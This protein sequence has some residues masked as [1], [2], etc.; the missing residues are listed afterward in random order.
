MYHPVFIFLVYFL[1]GYVYRPVADLIMGGQAPIWSVT[2]LNPG[3]SDIIYA[4]VVSIVALGSFVFLPLLIFPKAYDGLVIIRTSFKVDRP[5]LFYLTLGISAMLGIVGL[6]NAFWTADSESL[7]AFATRVQQSGGQEL[8]GISGYETISLHF[9]PAVIILLY[10]RLG[11]KAWLVAVTA[12]YL[13]FRAYFGV[14][15]SGFVALFL[16]LLIAHMIRSGIR[17]FNLKHLAAAVLVLF[18]FDVIGGNRYA[19]KNILSGAATVNEVASDYLS[20]RGAGM[21]L[22]DLEEFESTTMVTMIV[23]E[24]TGYNW[25]TQYLRLFIW[26]IPRQ[27]WPD[28]PVFTSKIVWIDYGN[29]FGQ[30]NSMIGDA[31]SNLGVFSVAPMMGLY[32]LG[33]SLLYRAAQRKR[34][35]YW[36][37][38]F[39][40]VSMNLPLL[41][42][43]GEVGAYYFMIASMLGILPALWLGR[44]AV[45]E[46]Q[47]LRKPASDMYPRGLSL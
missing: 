39:V 6:I 13:S 38:V 44:P 32:G 3:A 8:E 12:V 14:E 42:R 28:K 29:F 18:L 25:F 43:N 2:G 22:S 16:G 10:L 37:V 34:S 11:E 17:A 15:R 30:T 47:S 33:L 4:A 7:V 35:P 23:P 26:P 46:V 21:P 9:L 20:N 40:I 1:F 5:I 36:I 45:E 27:W 41:Y 19:L 31:Y 24:L